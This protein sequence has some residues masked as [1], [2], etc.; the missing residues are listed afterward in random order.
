VGPMR[1]G[2]LLTSENYK[3]PSSAQLSPL[4]CKNGDYLHDNNNDTSLRMITVCQS[5]KN[6]TKFEY[7][8]VN[9]VFCLNNCPPPPPPPAPIETC[10]SIDK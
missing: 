1:G 8:E 4:T 6:R 10:D 2:N 9:A 5:G 7:T 3:I